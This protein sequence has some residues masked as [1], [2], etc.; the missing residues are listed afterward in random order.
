MS[1][2]AHPYRGGSVA[3]P[4]RL[5]RECDWREWSEPSR[6]AAELE[7]SR[8]GIARGTL[9]ALGAVYVSIVYV[10]PDISSWILAAVMALV[11][12]LFLLFLK[13]RPRVTARFEI[14]PTEARYVVGSRSLAL[15]TDSVTGVEAYKTPRRRSDDQWSD[16]DI[17]LVLRDGEKKPLYLYSSQSLV[18]SRVTRLGEAFA[19]LRRP[20]TRRSREL[21]EIESEYDAIHTPTSRHHG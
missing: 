6:F 10:R 11:Y 1:V 17:R 5:N 12:M 18:A 13:S 9:L 4:G 7:F 14:T 19:S 21:Y 3:A 20:A 8:A 16:W 15:D 2:P